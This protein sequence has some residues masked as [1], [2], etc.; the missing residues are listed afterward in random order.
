VVRVLPV[1]LALA[2]CDSTPTCPTDWD[3]HPDDAAAHLLATCGDAAPDALRGWIEQEAKGTHTYAVPAGLEDLWGRACPQVA[4]LGADP[5]TAAQGC[6]LPAGY[7]P[8]PATA[9]DQYRG[10]PVLGLVV[11]AWLADAGAPVDAAA[12]AARAIRGA[13]PY[14]GDPI[15]L[16]VA[17]GEGFDGVADTTIGVGGVAGRV[18]S[19]RTGEGPLA[20][21]LGPLHNGWSVEAW[22]PAVATPAV[23]AADGRAPAQDLIRLAA[24]VVPAGGTFQLLGD[25]GA[26]VGAIELGILAP[27]AD[28]AAVALTPAGVM[29]RTD[30]AWSDACTSVEGCTAFAAIPA[31]HPVGIVVSQATT[32][33]ELVTLASLFPGR[34]RLDLTDS[35]CAPA[36]DGMTCVAG[37]P[38]PVGAADT[39]RILQISSFYIDTSPATT[40][41]YK[42][43]V[44]AGFCEPAGGKPSWGAADRYCTWAGKR[45]PTEWEWEKAAVQ[46]VRGERAEWTRSWKESDLTTCGLACTAPDPLGP[47]GGAEPCERASQRVRR[48]A[49]AITTRTGASP[50]SRADTGIR[51]AVSGAAT[52]DPPAFFGRGI[53]VRSPALTRS[54]PFQ[55]KNQWPVLSTPEAP[56]AAELAIVSGLKSDAIEDKVVCPEDVVKT[57]NF[58]RGQGGRSELDCR[59]PIAYIETNEK[60][61]DTFTDLIQNIGGAYS[62]VGADQNYD[63]IALAKSRWAFLFDYEPNVVRLHRVLKAV[64]LGADSPEAFVAG[65]SA[66]GS[67]ATMDRIADVWKDDPQM[68]T[69]QRFF[70]GYRTRLEA[71][72][73]RQLKQRPED[74]RFGW[75]S[76]LD[77]YTYIRTLYQ[78]GRI[79]ALP[80]DMLAKTTMREVGRATRELGVPMRIF[81]TSNAPTSWGGGITT[82]WRENVGAL[83][84]D[85]ASLALVTWNRGSFG[86]TDYWHYNAQRG[87]TYQ[88]R[89]RHPGY[90]YMW[91][92]VWDRIPGPDANLTLTNIAGG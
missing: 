25:A 67:D 35:P 88:A 27:D 89:L 74:A 31:D 50:S 57:W 51:C 73:T 64:I 37:G 58:P 42:A 61:L 60:R 17:S 3:A 1:L 11:Y 43:C 16:P 12:A 92:M 5:L 14:P 36:L 63:L 38:T 85:D 71:I 39:R 81:Y 22:T 44:D 52:Q 66:A 23:F 70:L 15:E 26:F 55:S 24:S 53:D 90:Q 48:D 9:F 84:F 33:S 47:C 2:A 7:A 40:D 77:Q 75:L 86:G 19:P 4:N 91:Q 49:S 76:H 10:N 41:D 62:G 80:G 65:F 87:L 29:L 21:P 28:H 78:Q 8:V 83:P 69:Y 45:L 20:L 82:E 59:D 13:L 18:S 32:V 54:P 68:A 72:Y 46:G 6:A 30:G 56:T 34:A 79:V